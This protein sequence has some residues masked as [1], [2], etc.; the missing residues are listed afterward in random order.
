MRLQMSGALPQLF[1]PLTWVSYVERLDG[2][3][4]GLSGLVRWGVLWGALIFP[5]I[6]RQ[7][8][9]RPRGTAEEQ[10]R[11]LVAGEVADG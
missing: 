8:V 11:T 9:T 1:L 10:E 4:P 2:V 6:A 5:W 3:G 7:A